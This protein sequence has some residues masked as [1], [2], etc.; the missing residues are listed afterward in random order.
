MLAADPAR[1]LTDTTSILAAARLP[2]PPAPVRGDGSRGLVAVKAPLA[3]FAGAALAGAP[4]I[5]PGA[6]AGPP[7]QL[8]TAPG[9]D[10][11]LHT[12]TAPIPQLEKP[13]RE[14]GVGPK[15]HKKYR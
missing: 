5:G 10:Q 6:L 9:C 13:C 3:G 15:A 4:Q 7:G 11:R 8:V 14:R 1:S 2:G 12:W